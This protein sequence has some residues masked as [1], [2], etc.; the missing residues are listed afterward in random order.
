MRPRLLYVGYDYVVQE[1]RTERIRNTY[2]KRKNLTAGRFCS[3]RTGEQS[4]IVCSYY[5]IFHLVV[6]FFL[7]LLSLRSAMIMFGYGRWEKIRAQANVSE[8]SVG[9]VATVCRAMIAVMLQMEAISISQVPRTAP[10]YGNSAGV[11][12]QIVSI[13]LG[14]ALAA[15][16]YMASSCGSSWVSSTS[17]SWTLAALRQRPYRSSS[18]RSCCSSFCNSLQ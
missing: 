9:D 11:P 14:V 12:W 3:C 2:C 17:N 5:I 7:L 10:I 18:H 1:T 15:C 13:R 4:C 16:W 8:R 6:I